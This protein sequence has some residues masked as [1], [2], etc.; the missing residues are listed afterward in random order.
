MQANRPNPCV[1]CTLQWPISSH[2]RPPEVTHFSHFRLLTAK[3]LQIALN[4]VR[5][6]RLTSRFLPYRKGRLCLA[7]RTRQPDRRFRRRYVLFHAKVPN[8]EYFVVARRNKPHLLWIY[9]TRRC[10]VNSPRR[11]WTCTRWAIYC[12]GI[13]TTSL[14]TFCSN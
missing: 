11:T 2:L 13:P 1:R 5:H 10:L 3:S 6:V 14:V 4:R 8:P 7:R 12:A 9:F